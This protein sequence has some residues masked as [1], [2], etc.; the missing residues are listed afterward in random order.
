M[1]IV[2]YFINW[3]D[4]FYLP[5]IKEHYGKFCEKIVMYDHY[6]TDGS[7]KLARDLGFEVRY[8]GIKNQLNDQHYLDIKNHCWKEC[9]GKGINYVIVCDTDEFVFPDFNTLSLVEPSAPKVVGYNMISEE[10]PKLSI[11][12]IRLGQFSHD[13]SKQAIFSPDRIQEIN[14][15]HGCHR[16]HITGDIT[17]GGNTKLY[18]L[19][20]IGGVERMIKRHEEYRRRLSKFNKQHKMGFHYEHSDNAKRE[21]WDFLKKNAIEL[22]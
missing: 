8:F 4:S 15:V 21:E 10:L 9:R 5:F 7:V 17:S 18:H 11:Q 3:N 2:L 16:N 1:R 12:E 13:Y 6:S 14:Y 22:W 19:R 20:M